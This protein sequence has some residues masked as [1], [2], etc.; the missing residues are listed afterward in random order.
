MFHLML[1]A[2]EMLRSYYLLQV[3][4]GS[5]HSFS[6]YLSFFFLPRSLRLSEL[7]EKIPRAAKFIRLYLDVYSMGGEGVYNSSA[8]HNISVDNSL[9]TSSI[10]MSN[11]ISNFCLSRWEIL[12]KLFFLLFSLPFYFSRGLHLSALATSLNRCLD[13][14]Q[15]NCQVGV[16]DF[17]TA[18][19]G[20]KLA[21]MF[22]VWQGQ[23][24]GEGCSPRGGGGGGGCWD[25]SS[26]CSGGV[27]GGPGFC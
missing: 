9:Q 7:I 26:R 20:N 2:G 1:L 11:S 23:R 8:F 27:E 4:E 21:K 15:E 25:R 12:E 3:K 6:L 19:T 13:Q 17:H 10:V 5:F 14:C 24:S 16:I 18:A 22:Q